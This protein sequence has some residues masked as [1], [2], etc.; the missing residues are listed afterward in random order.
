M[1]ATLFHVA[2]YQPMF[3]IFVGLYN[4]IPGHDVGIVIFVITL[5][6]RALVYPLTTSSIKAQRSLQELQPKLEALKQKYANDKQAQ[7]QATMELYKN[8]QVNP[9]TSCLPMLVQLPILI[10]LYLVLRDGLAS[11][12]IA[13]SLYAFV[14]NPGFINPVSLGIF[15]LAQPSTVFS[16]LAGAAQFWQARGLMKKTPPPGAGAGAKDETMMAMMNKQMLYV[17]PAL[18]A[19]IGFRLPSGLTLYWFVS[20]TLM[21]LQQQLLAKKT[22][23]SAGPATPVIEGKIVG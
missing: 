11:K 14:H 20:T 3:N 10:A 4:I 16:L 12:D 1:F 15:D 8:H 17:M 22:P 6:V 2:L 19:I 18:T 21:A 23:T 13:A 9:L 5:A 7:A